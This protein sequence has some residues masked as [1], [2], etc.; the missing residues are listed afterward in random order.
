VSA[1]FRLRGFYIKMLV[2]PHL[3]DLPLVFTLA[4]FH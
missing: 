4:K 1:S 3:N 2:E